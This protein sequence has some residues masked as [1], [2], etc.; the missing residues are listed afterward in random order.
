M[1]CDVLFQM[2]YSKDNE[3]RIWRQCDSS[4]YVERSLLGNCACDWPSYW[5][6]VMTFR[7]LMLSNDSLFN[8][9]C[10]QNYFCQS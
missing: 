3:S 2:L 7:H 1:G 4:S 8:M 9:G 10:I 5:Y 6:K